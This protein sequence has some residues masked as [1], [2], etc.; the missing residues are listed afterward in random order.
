MNFLKTISLYA[1][2]IAGATALIIGLI[3]IFSK[4]GSSV[5]VK[6]GFV[7]AAAMLLVC[8]TGLIMSVLKTDVFLLC[9]SVFSFY[10]L[11]TGLR[12]FYNP[13]RKFGLADWPVVILG[14]I[15][16]VYMF[17][18]KNIILISFA[19]ILL[20][21]VIEDVRRNFSVNEIK[22]EKKHALIA[23]IGRMLGSYLASLTAFLVVNSDK[24]P[25]Q[26]WVVWLGPTFVIVPFII[27][28]S[29]M[30]KNKLGIKGFFLSE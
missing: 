18:T 17:Y 12:W 24:F 13:T 10:M 3:P 8:I 20:R 6:T 7:Y 21:F 28:Y 11:Y 9:I 2:I 4:K 19:F 29:R 23:H 25:V 5:H 22:E 1:H 26:G 16:M 27:F 15:F 30:Y 14:T